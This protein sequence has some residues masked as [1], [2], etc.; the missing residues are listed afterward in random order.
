MMPLLVQAFSLCIAIAAQL[1]V[2]AAFDVVVSVGAAHASTD[3][4]A[5]L[6]NNV[7]TSPVAS[8]WMLASTD[9]A[10]TNQHNLKLATLYN[11]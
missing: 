8:T 10:S 2:A 5:P 1:P 7:I 9:C 4:S 6:G 11:I 3:V